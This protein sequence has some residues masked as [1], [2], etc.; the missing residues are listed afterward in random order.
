MSTWR[1]IWKK[2]IIANSKMVKNE[3]EGLKE[4]SKLLNEYRD[5]ETNKEDG[6]I[7]YAMGESY[8]YL[9]KY[10]AANNEYSKAKELFPVLH[11]KNVAQEAIDRV[12]RK[13]IQNISTE[14]FYRGENFS[15]LLWYLFQKVWELVNLDDFARYI[16]LSAVSRADS[17]WPLSLT[18]FRSVLEWQIKKSFPKQVKNL[19]DNK[20]FTLENI[21]NKLQDDNLINQN[22]SKSMHQIRQEGN[23]AVHELETIDKNAKANIR[24]FLNVLKFFNNEADYD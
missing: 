16:C 10:D 8:E 6:M 9:K 14:Y 24:N 12:N 2:S 3:K 20:N 5:K 1:D 18:D 23:L 7:H 22:V 13:K 15:T 4:F 11:W 17:E 21:I 19:I